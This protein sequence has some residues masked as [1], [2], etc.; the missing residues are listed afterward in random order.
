MARWFFHFTC[1]KGFQIDSLKLITD[2]LLKYLISLP[3]SLRKRFL[4]LMKRISTL[5]SEGCWAAFGLLF[6]GHQ[7]LGHTQL[8]EG[9]TVPSHTWRKLPVLPRVRQA[10]SPLS[11]RFLWC[12]LPLLTCHCCSAMGQ[13]ALQS[14]HCPPQQSPF[15]LKTLP[16]LFPQPPSKSGWH[17]F[18]TFGIGLEGRSGEITGWTER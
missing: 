15:R 1:T 4:G 17:C 16:L 10:L 13:R 12:G 6:L 5:V 11:R 7:G 9:H 8:Q 18:P 14:S 2:L 3:R